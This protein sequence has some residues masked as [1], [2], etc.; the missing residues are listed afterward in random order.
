MKCSQLIPLPEY[1]D[2]YINMAPNGD[3]LNDVQNYK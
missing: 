2:K 3:V 1:F